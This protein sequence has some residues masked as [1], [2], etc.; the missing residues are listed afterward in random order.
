MLSLRDLGAHS[1]KGVSPGML[2]AAPL[3]PF[4]GPKVETLGVTATRG[5][6]RLT[7][8]KPGQSLTGGTARGRYVTDGTEGVSFAGCPWVSAPA[9]EAL[10]KPITL[11]EIFQKPEFH[12]VA[13]TYLGE[14][15]AFFMRCLMN[16]NARCAFASGAF[17]S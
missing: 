3:G 2:T 14:H 6:A 9:R 8:W 1:E 5:G 12:D 15:A 7:T 10:Y 4:F 16:E 17:T 13:T 11:E